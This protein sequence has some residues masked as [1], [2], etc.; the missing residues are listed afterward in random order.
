MSRFLILSVGLVV[1]ACGSASPAQERVAFAIVVSASEGEAR[2]DASAGRVYYASTTTSTWSNPARNGA[3]DTPVPQLG[4]LH[5]VADCRALGVPRFV[6]LS[7]DA[8]R[9]VALSD[10]RVLGWDVET[11]KQFLQLN[12]TA[13]R[14][15]QTW[16][17][18]VTHNGEEWDWEGKVTGAQLGTGSEFRQLNQLIGLRHVMAITAHPDIRQRPYPVTVVTWA[19]YA[20]SGDALSATI[21]LVRELA[22]SGSGAFGDDARAAIL[23]S[24]GRLVVVVPRRE[25]EGYPQ[26]TI[27]LDQNFDFEPREIS[28]IE[29]NYYLVGSAKGQVTDP[30]N[31]DAALTVATSPEQTAD[32][33]KPAWTRDEPDSTLRVVGPD[34]Q[35]RWQVSVP[36]AVRQPAVR[37]ADGAVYLV[38]RGVAAAKDGRVLWQLSELGDYTAT[39][40]EDGRL[41]LSSD[42]RLM[43]MSP[44]GE[45]LQTVTVPK[46]E[47]ITTPAAVSSQGWVFVA[48]ERAVYRAR[49]EEPEDMPFGSRM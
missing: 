4:D 24:D 38:G 3:I 40:D 22:G 11:G 34:G 44:Q 46:G 19:Q 1:A 35:Q 17:T 12:D 45:L 31:Q 5:A 26:A 7:P 20:G 13:G 29:P 23:L 47:R 2:P 37:G 32:A 28:I 25:R 41:L 36:F 15:V 9:L 33:A 10:D 49:I 18:G 43:L 6:V 30:K 42:H 8:R 21:G 14:L 16:P 27:V 48:T 39:S